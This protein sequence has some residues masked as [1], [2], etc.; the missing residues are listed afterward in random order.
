[1]FVGREKCVGKRCLWGERCVED[2]KKEKMFE[3]ACCNNS[4]SKSKSSRSSLSSSNSNLNSS[5]RSLA[6]DDYPM[7]EV[8]EAI[9]LILI[10]IQTLSSTLLS[11][12]SCSSS[13]ISKDI[14]SNSPFPSFPT[15]MMDGYVVK[16]PLKIGSYQIQNKIFAGDEVTPFDISNYLPTLSL[17]FSLSFPCPSFS[18]SILLSSLFYSIFNLIFKVKFLI[19]QLVHKFQKVQMLL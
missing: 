17:S 2:Q 12:S 3:C 9:H 11:I 8:D 15:S 18:S 19:L 5:K 1:M 14:V 13:Y 10:N 7:I 6:C 4:N 16:A